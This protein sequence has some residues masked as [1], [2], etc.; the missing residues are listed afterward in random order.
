MDKQGSWTELNWLSFQQAMLP[1]CINR[2]KAAPDFGRKR[3]VIS[4]QSGT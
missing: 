1:N 2:M 3:Q 4:V